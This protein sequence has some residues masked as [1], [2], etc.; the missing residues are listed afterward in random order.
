M[1]SYGLSRDLKKLFVEYGPVKVMEVWQNT[2]QEFRQALNEYD[3]KPTTIVAKDVIPE[4]IKN[5][6][7]LPLSKPSPDK[8]KEAQKEKM[9][10]HREKIA[11]KRQ[12]LASKGIIPE[13]QLTDEN[14]KR[15]IQQE[16]KNYWTIAEETGCNDNDIGN[17]AKT[18]NILSEVAM[19]IRKK[20]AKL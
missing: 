16:N 6:I 12:E 19:M 20:R 7:E 1:D 8:D 13:T 9:K 3:T 5:P 11:A 4:V 17:I 14:L 10:L 15:W 2:L 18:K